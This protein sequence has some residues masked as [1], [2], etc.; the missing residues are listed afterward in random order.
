MREEKTNM[1]EE[2]GDA[3]G[4]LGWFFLGTLVG[5]GVALLLTPRTGRETRDI[6]KE[7]GEEFARRAGE[8]ASEAQV[9]AGD[10]FDKGREFFEEQSQRLVSAFEAGKAAMKEEV[11]RGRQES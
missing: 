1:A 10:L 11:S 7:K 6:L 3:A 9:K 5:A 2:R 4:Y 8:V